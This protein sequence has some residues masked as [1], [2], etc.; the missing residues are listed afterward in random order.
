MRVLCRK[1]NDTPE[2]GSRPMSASACG[3][4]PGAGAGI[5]ILESLE[6]AR[7]RRA[8]I[9]A[10]IL[11]FHVNSGGQRSGGTM[12]LPSADGVRRCIQQAMVDAEIQPKDIDAIN[13]HLTAT[14]ADPYELQNWTEALGREGDN[15]P[16]INA[17][18][19]MIGHCLGAAGAIETIGAVLQLNAGFLHPSI[20]CEDIHPQ[21][22]SY[23]RRIVGNTCVVPEINII[24]KTSF[25]FGDVNGCLILKKWTDSDGR[26]S[27]KPILYRERKTPLNNQGDSDEPSRNV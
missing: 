24:A 6:S 7:E 18:K 19:S 1:F 8:P 4:V 9:Y 15:F 14:M 25:G 22:T 20:N 3:F 13:G 10:E 2:N 17:T 21:L 12:T 5:L 16:Y 27:I 23:K 11:G 26:Q